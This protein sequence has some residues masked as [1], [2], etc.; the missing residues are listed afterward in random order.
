VQL[1]PGRNTVN[2]FEKTVAPRELFLG[3]VFEV[4]EALL[5]DRWRAGNVP[6]LSQVAA[7]VGTGAGELISASLGESARR[8]ESRKMG[9]TLDFHPACFCEQRM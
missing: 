3:S 6:L 9:V 4:G 5:H 8:E 2:L 7:L 1:A